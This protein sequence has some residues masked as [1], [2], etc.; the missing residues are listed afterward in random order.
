MSSVADIEKLPSRLWGVAHRAASVNCDA[1]LVGAECRAKIG[2]GGGG[3]PLAC[4]HTWGKLGGA[5][6]FLR[7]NLEL[8]GAL[9]V[10]IPLIS[11]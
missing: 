2:P 5:S 6:K 11:C 3:H 9:S 7:G 4:L 10:G 8:R 1:S